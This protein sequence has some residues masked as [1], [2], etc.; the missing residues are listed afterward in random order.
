MLVERKRDELELLTGF[1][2]CTINKPFG[3]QTTSSIPRLDEIK[4]RYAASH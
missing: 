4:V 2:G 1:Y 3:M